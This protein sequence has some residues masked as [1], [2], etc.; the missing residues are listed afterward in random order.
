METKIANHHEQA[1]KLIQERHYLPTESIIGIEVGTNTGLL[2]VTLLREVPQIK[3]LFT[4]DPWRHFPGEG[5]EAGNQQEYHDRQKA[6]AMWR[7]KTYEDRLVFMQMTSDDAFNVL[8][9]S[10]VKANFVWI[11]GHHTY[12]QAKKDIL[13]AQDV[14]APYY[15]LGGHDYN[16]VDDVQKAVHEVLGKENIETGFDY[17]W[18]EKRK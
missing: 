8:K 2:T 17:T 16:L 7:L 5:F 18:W 13:N 6:E 11:D 12:A 10:G 14:L 4:I 1:L 9:T 3:T 15:L